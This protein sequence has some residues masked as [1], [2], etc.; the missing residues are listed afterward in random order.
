M[1]ETVPFSADATAAAVLS[2][3]QFL[4][5]IYLDEA[6]IMRP[7]Y[8]G[9]QEI[10]A[11]TISLL[12]K[13]EQVMQLLRKLPYVRH[14]AEI[15]P[16]Q[17]F[18]DWPSWIR[19]L[20]EEPQ[21]AQRLRGLTESGTFSPDV[22]ASVIGLTMVDPQGWTF[23][24]DSESGLVHWCDCPSFITEERPPVEYIVETPDDEGWQAEP[25][26]PI[27]EFFDILKDQYRQLNFCPTSHR[28]VDSIETIQLPENRGI[29]ESVQSVF[30]K[31]GWPDDPSRYDKRLCLSEVK[32]KLEAD[33]PDYAEFIAAVF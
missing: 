28:T 2:F 6:S 11:D 12:G 20:Q 29:V 33:F 1:A 10:T 14:G 5:T 32:A 4:T 16:R 25:A 9:W 19:D 22:P 26:W 17:H 13:T 27:A 7:P 24:L 31:H 15:I 23:L 3:Y 18:V 30:R 21:G 8:D